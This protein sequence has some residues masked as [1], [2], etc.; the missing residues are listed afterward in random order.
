M[1]GWSRFQAEG[2]GFEPVPAHTKA[3]E[4]GAFSICRLRR[5]LPDRGRSVRLAARA[6]AYH[7]ADVGTSA[8]A[9]EHLPM[10][11][12]ELESPLSPELVLVSPDLRER[13]LLDDRDAPLPA[14]ADVDPPAHVDPPPASVPPAPPA[15]LP[16]PPPVLTPA[17]VAGP[18][19]RRP[20]ARIAI[21]IALAALIV[22]GVGV[23]I[24]K[25]AFPTSTSGSPAALRSASP[26]PSVT[27]PVPR[28]SS[29]ASTTVPARAAKSS[30][31][32]ARAKRPSSASAAPRS[33][34]SQPSVTVPVPRTSSTASTIVPARAAKSSA[35]P[36]RAKR[37]SSASA[38]PRG[39]SSQPSVTVPV[40]RTSSTA[41]TTVPARA[42]EV[43]GGTGSCRDAVED[44][45][46]CTQR[47]LRLFRGEL[48]ALRHRAKDRELHASD[49]VLWSLDPAADASC[50]NRDICVLGKARRGF[51]GDDG[52]CHRTLRLTSRGARNHASYT[53]HMPRFGEAVR[54]PPELS[55]RWRKVRLGA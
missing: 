25:L 54:R 31:A 38:A 14:P 17:Q 10:A 1:R 52:R 32:P 7:P 26:Q 28:T 23:A 51:V 3:P 16:S 15:P 46:S 6:H 44:S 11:D 9:R 39:A 34:S 55:K 5:T 36:A 37:P 20:T 22:F 42:A 13:A 50:G 27:V 35:A 49:G 33:A 21:A 24:G 48:P 30:A 2:R 41:S 19:E 53:R 43:L 45:S 4:T 29:T 12:P 8:L 47:R 18:V 40:P